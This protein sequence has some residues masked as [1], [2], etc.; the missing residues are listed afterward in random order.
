MVTRGRDKANSGLSSV[1]DDAG[2]A[3]A[4]AQETF[5]AEEMKVFSG[6]PPNELV[7][8]HLHRFIQVVYMCQ[9][10]FFFSFFFFFFALF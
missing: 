10:F 4:K 6:T 5:I 7:S 2:V 1:W 9:F 8:R 3:Q